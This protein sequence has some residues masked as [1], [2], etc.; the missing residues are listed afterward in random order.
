[1]PKDLAT[2]ISY[3]YCAS[4]LSGA[5]SGLLAAGIAEMDGVGGYEGWRWIFILEGIPTVLIGVACYFLLIDT[6]ALSTRWLEPDEIRYL[7]ISMFIKQG[8]MFR[9]ENGFRW[10]DLKMVL[11]NWRIYMQA[12]FLFVQSALSYGKRKLSWL[13]TFLKLFRSFVSHRH[14]IYSTHHHKGYGFQQ[15]RGATIICTSVCRSRNIGH[16]IRKSLRSFLLAD[17][18]RGHPHGHRRRRVL[19]LPWL[20]RGPRHPARPGVLRR[21]STVHRYLPHPARRSILECEQHRA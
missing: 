5:F 1:M 2:R 9:A 3:F 7:E 11:S 12:Y 20:E 21:S 6:P 19:H 10:K 18:L 17:A 16:C 4:A 15:H 14:K 13:T 8:G